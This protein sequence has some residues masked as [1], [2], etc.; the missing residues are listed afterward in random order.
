MS[1]IK[2]LLAPQNTLIP[3]IKTQKYSF[4]SELSTL[5]FNLTMASLH[6]VQ[7]S[8]S[9]PYIHIH[10][11]LP[12]LKLERNKK[13]VLHS[14][15]QNI[16]STFSNG[17]FDSPEPIHRGRK[18]KP[19]SSS[20]SSTTIPPPPKKT[21]CSRKI[22]VEN[23][24]IKAKNRDPYPELDEIEDYDDTFDLLLRRCTQRVCTHS[25]LV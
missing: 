4:F 20:S 6:L 1:L 8:L 3:N 5:V 19:T 13:K 16:A 12:R 10:Y 2:I 7:S 17:A 18:K 14:Q 22:Q 11:S 25:W 15:P 23:A 9:F 24:T 21:K